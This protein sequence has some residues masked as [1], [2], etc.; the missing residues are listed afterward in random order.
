M[1]LLTA[2]MEDLADIFIRPSRHLYKN[3]DLGP[4]NMMIEGFKVARHDF[5]VKNY[6]KLS[7]KCSYYYRE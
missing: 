6:R 1:N 3:T 7:L 4:K 2:N 5:E